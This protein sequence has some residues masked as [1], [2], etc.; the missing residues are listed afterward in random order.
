MK[1]LFTAKALKDYESLTDNLQAV[2]DKQL[3]ALLRDIRYPSLRAKKYNESQD[4]WQVRIN[5]DYR[6]Y[7]CIDGDIYIVITICKHP[8]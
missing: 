2:V 6:A 5:K 1:L 8:K 4:I 7:F 3:E